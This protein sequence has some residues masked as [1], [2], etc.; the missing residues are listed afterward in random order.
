MF[1]IFGIKPIKEEI[2]SG[3]FYCPLCDRWTKYL[4]ARIDQWT[5]LF[6]MRSARMSQ[7]KPF[8]ECTGCGAQVLDELLK[9]RPSRK[10][11]GLLREW[12]QGL[13]S[14]VSVNDTLEQFERHGMP[15]DLADAF[16]LEWCDGQV[17][18]CAR[19]GYEYH[20]AVRKCRDC[21]AA[22]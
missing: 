11:R 10:S 21:K 12:H 13:R 4:R 20:P 2:G 5:T 3:T 18:E 22:L 9:F 15:G 7:G 6:Y 17:R 1:V 8:V 14:G 16:V 19:C